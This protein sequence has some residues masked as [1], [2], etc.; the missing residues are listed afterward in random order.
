VVKMTNG[1]INLIIVDLMNSAYPY[2]QREVRRE[3]ISN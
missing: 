1:M 3:V 2:E